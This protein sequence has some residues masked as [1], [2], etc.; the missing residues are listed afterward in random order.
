MQKRKLRQ[1]EPCRRKAEPDCAKISTEDPRTKG[2]DLSGD[3]CAAIK[4]PP[5]AGTAFSIV[6]YFLNIGRAT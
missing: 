1:M 6:C 2:E 3:G 4:K 5:R